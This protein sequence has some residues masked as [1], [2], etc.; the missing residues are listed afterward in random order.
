MCMFS[1]PKTPERPDPEVERKKTEAEAQQKANQGMAM[2]KAV[3]RRS[4]LLASGA[5]GVQGDAPT[6]SVL[7]YGKKAL[8]E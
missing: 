5:Q 7:A 4:S 3:Q 8:G 1:S 6:S 2:R